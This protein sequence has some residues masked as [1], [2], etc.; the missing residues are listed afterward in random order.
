MNDTDGFTQGLLLWRY[1][2]EL[3]IPE[4]GVLRKSAGEMCDW[5][6][7]KR[8]EAEGYPDHLHMLVEIRPKMSV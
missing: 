4:K 5:K 6:Q 3:R 2:I 8:I 1:H 7:V